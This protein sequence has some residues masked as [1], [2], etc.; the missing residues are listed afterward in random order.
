[1]VQPDTHPLQTS[2]NKTS[3]K[4]IMLLPNNLTCT[5]ILNH[6]N[7]LPV[8]THRAKN[9][10]NY[11]PLNT[12]HWIIMANIN[13]K[14]TNMQRK[15]NRTIKKLNKD[16]GGWSG[17]LW[18]S[19][20]C[21]QVVTL[22]LFSNFWWH[23]AEMHYHIFFKQSHNMWVFTIIRLCYTIIKFDCSIF[24]LTNKLKCKSQYVLTAQIN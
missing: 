11:H 16:T 18:M 14:Q 3:H 24:V 21:V 8:V 5:I 15:L 10:Y 13:H 4:L 7:H 17:I 9:L 19:S 1:M 23:S 12:H 6:V 22:F 2:T 20:S